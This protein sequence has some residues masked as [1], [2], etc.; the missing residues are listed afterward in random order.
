MLHNFAPL[1]DEAL[2]SLL[3]E[4]VLEKEQGLQVSDLNDISLENAIRVGDIL[5]TLFLMSIYGQWLYFNEDGEQVV[6]EQKV[7][8]DLFAQGRVGLEDLAHLTGVW[9]PKG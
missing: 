3:V 1:W 8:D 5:E 2:E 6:L 9:K 4:A 7:M